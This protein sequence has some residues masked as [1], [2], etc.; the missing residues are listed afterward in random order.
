MQVI[1]SGANRVEICSVKKKTDFDRRFF[2]TRGQLYFVPTDALVRM[3]VIEYGKK[4][5][6]EAVII[7]KENEIVPYDPCDIEW[8]MDNLL[9]DI[10][11]YKEMS[12]Y[13]WFQKNR[14]WFVNV[15]QSLIRRILADP[16]MA[17]VGIVLL[18]M[19]LSGGI[20]L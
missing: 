1:I 5:Q 14:P 11:R 16:G 6:S 20:K 19:F 3:Q 13:R 10:D 12:N 9:A 7:Y 2:L 18:W 15:G 4:R 8:S 17:I